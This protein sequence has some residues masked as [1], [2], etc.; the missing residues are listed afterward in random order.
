MRE[1]NDVLQTALAAADIG[2]LMTTAGQG[3]RA[4][5]IMA[6]K[7]GKND[8]SDLRVQGK[9]GPGANQDQSGPAPRR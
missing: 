9:P 7:P 5:R 6:M 4:P 3:R 2:S 8:L 1:L